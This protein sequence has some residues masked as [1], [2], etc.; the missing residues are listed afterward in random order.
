[1]R[2]FVYYNLHKHCWSVRYKGKVIK[3]L[4]YITLSDCEFKVSLAGQRRV[5][6]ERRKNVHAGVYG[7]WVESTK[8]RGKTCE[9]VTYNP[10]RGPYFTDSVGGP[11]HSAE[12]V[13]MKNGKVKAW[14]IT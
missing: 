8:A 11:V 3:H 4:D 1:M 5:I 12:L 10:Y 13:V 14:G 9:S 7:I 2:V 6:K